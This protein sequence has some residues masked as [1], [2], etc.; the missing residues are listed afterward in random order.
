MGEITAGAFAASGP[1]PWGEKRLVALG[2]HPKMPLGASLSS[3]PAVLKGK[4]RGKPPSL[5]GGDVSPRLVLGAPLLSCKPYR[6]LGTLSEE[7]PIF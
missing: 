5:P 1:L 2:G 3:P 6:G 4:P 7:P